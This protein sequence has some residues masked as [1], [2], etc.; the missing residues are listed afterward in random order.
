M[1]RVNQGCFTET[2]RTSSLSD[3]KLLHTNKET[4]EWCFYVRCPNLFI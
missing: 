4:F 1:D 3:L 2:F